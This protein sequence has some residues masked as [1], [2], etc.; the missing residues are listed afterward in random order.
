MKFLG[1]YIISLLS[2]H[3]CTEN[4]NQ[5][6]LEAEH[7]IEMIYV[8]V[9]CCIFLL[10]VYF[11]YRRKL[12]QRNRKIAIMKKMYHNCVTQLNIAQQE[13]ANLQESNKKTI[14]ALAK[15]QEET[16]LKLQA[17]VKKYEDSNMGHSLLEL[18]YQ[19]KQSS[20]YQK[21]SYLENHPL[22]KMTKGDWENLEATVEKLVLSFAS[23]K[24]KLN[25]KEYHICLLVK[26]HFS[27]S[28][29][30]RFIGTSLPD[31]SNYRQKMLLKIC[32]K[33][34]KSK[35]FDEYIRSLL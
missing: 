32:G 19:L 17:E 31:I 1:T 14:A 24:Q 33:A 30:S 2:Q 6:L 28:T 9:I 16:I 3:S 27:P 7:R 25:T 12:K 34:G 8:I 4:K 10:V 35:E 13:L 20:I 21:L 5:L 29:T 18:D 11:F 26:L 23:L 15:E 22:E